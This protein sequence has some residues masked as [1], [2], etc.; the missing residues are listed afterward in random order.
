MIYIILSIMFIVLIV[1]LVL[2]FNPVFG[3]N[4]T[5]KQ[6]EDF[7]KLENYHNRKFQNPTSTKVEVKLENIPSMLKK[8][9]SKGENR[10]PSKELQ[11]T[12]IDW[13][14]V[15]SPEDS[16]TWLGH[17]TFLL[18]IDNSKILVDPMLEMVASPITLVGGKRYS[19]D[20][21]KILDELPQIDT[22]LI[23]HDHYDHLDY[24]TV[25]ALK[26]KVNLFFVPLGVDNHLLRWGVSKEKIVAMNWWEESE[27]NGLTIALTP[28]QHFSGRSLTNRDS[29]LWG[30][31]AILGKK[32]RIFTSGDGGYGPHFKEIG[33]KYGSFDL[34]LMEC[35]Q[36]NENWAATHMNPVQSVQ[37]SIDLNAKKLQPIHWG[38]FT[39]AF[40]EWTEPIEIAIKESK[41]KNIQ[42]VT[43]KLCETI[44]INEDSTSINAWW[45]EE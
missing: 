40:H 37:A 1:F 31:W 39:L 2:K 34:V 35:G 10:R 30:G 22:V 7:E 28:S 20:I 17:S 42:I 15:N 11:I 25:K 13:D 45:R 19:N 36:Y 33:N 41:E 21:S 8:F 24:P 27:F 12:D 18:S 16:V 3:G 38:A 32:S 43:S 29:T 26:D 6:K 23:T 14:K 5:K 44:L 9:L 4:P